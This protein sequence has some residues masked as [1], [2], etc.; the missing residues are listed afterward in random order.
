VLTTCAIDYRTWANKLPAGREVLNRVN[1]IRFPV[2]RRRNWRY[3]GWKSKRLFS[4]QHSLLDEY[5][6]VID[7]GPE[8]PAL[9]KYIRTNASDFDLFV[10]FTYLY[11]PTFFGLPMAAQKSVLIPTAHDE[12]AI[13]LDIFSTLF[14]LPRFI[15]F[16]TQEEQRFVHETFHNDYI[17][18]DVIGVGV[19]LDTTPNRDEGYLLYMGRIENGK[20]CNELFEF[21]RKAG[22]P[23]KMIGQ[24][25]IP[26][27]KHVE[28]LGVVNELEKSALLAECRALVVPS[29]NESL[30]LAVLEAWAH[31]KPVIVSAHSPV[32][33]A[34]VQKSGGG[35]SY[36]NDV[37]FRTIIQNVD[38]MRGLAGRR[39]VEE[40]YSWSKILEK[41]HEVFSFLMSGSSSSLPERQLRCT[42]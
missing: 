2:E 5:R 7:Q 3:F 9:I 4:T 23:L 21:I 11:Y 30:S 39:Y 17:P 35:Y 32:L 18:S 1:M 38:P 42:R 13:N 27:P 24:A 34:H 36:N 20:G 14:H 29:R 37:E 8:C 40:N 12:P 31:G 41:Y 16:N 15:A 19:D 10:F 6:W 26:I 22:V 28:Y 25:L 33:R